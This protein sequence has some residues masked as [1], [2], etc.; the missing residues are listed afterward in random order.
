MWVPLPAGPVET[1]NPA[2]GRPKTI[3]DFHSRRLPAFPAPVPGTPGTAGL[4]DTGLE[5]VFL[6]DSHAMQCESM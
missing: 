1:P 3:P 5:G 6:F 4:V 2:P